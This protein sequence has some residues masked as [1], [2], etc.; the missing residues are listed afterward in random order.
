MDAT[1]LEYKKEYRCRV[2]PKGQRACF[3]GQEGDR[4][5]FV[6]VEGNKSVICSGRYWMSKG[7]I[8]RFIE[9]ITNN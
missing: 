9:E 4:Y 2:A 8:E 3:I 5:W 6:S 7:Q 1:R